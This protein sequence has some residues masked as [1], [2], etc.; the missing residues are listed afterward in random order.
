MICCGENYQT[1]PNAPQPRDVCRLVWSNVSW[2]NLGLK[3]NYNIMFTKI[4]N[5]K[6]SS[7]NHV[8]RISPSALSVALLICS[9]VWLLGIGVCS[10]TGGYQHDWRGA[11]LWG[12]LI[13]LLTPSLCFALGF[14]LA[15]ARHPARLSGLEKCALI[16]ALLPVTLGSWLAI[17]AVKAW[18]WASFLEAPLG[19]RV[20]AGSASLALIL[21][22]GPML[23][24]SVRNCWT[25]KWPTDR[26]RA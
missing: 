26:P 8:A 17:V 7:S 9:L 14:V 12:M 5:W 3:L 19:L 18:F 20:L 25:A 23:W 11:P 10:A 15:N 24:Q 6:F 22:S 2:L 4:L 1:N 21:I 13:L 16:A